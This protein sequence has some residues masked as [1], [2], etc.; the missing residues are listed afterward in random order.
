MNAAL[1]ALFL[2]KYEELRR[3]VEAIARERGGLTDRGGRPIVDVVK[4]NT[5]NSWALE[6]W[7]PEGVD[8]NAAEYEA[9]LK[10]VLRRKAVRALKRA[11]GVRVESVDAMGPAGYYWPKRKRPGVPVVLWTSVDGW[12]EPKIDY[13]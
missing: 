7:E 6:F 5:L 9:E 2:A 11:A 8:V 3:V 13:V 4:T 10:R 1:E 12:P